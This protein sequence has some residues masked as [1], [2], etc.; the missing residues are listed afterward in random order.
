MLLAFPPIRSQE[1]GACRRRRRPREDGGTTPSLSD[2]GLRPVR[3]NRA[4]VEEKTEA[5]QRN[6]KEK[7]IPVTVAHG[8]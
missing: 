7:T 6:V 5:R 4:V 3:N 8:Y 1:P 2:T